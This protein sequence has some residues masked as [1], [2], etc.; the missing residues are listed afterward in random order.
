MGVTMYVQQIMQPMSAGTESMQKVM[1]LLP[2][3]FTF[4]F[5]GLPSGLVLYWTVNN[6]LSILQQRFMGGAGP[7]GGKGHS[8]SGA[9]KVA[10]GNKKG[11]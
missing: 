3:I 7:S 9:Q 11:A 6:I 1:R 4:I 8:E 10:N 5:A 2:I